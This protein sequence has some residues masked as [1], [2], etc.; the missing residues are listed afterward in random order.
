[1]KFF[2]YKGDFT[3]LHETLCNEIIYFN[4]C[5]INFKHNGKDIKWIRKLQAL[6]NYLNV[7]GNKCAESMNF[8]LNII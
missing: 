2:Y 3:L 8:D 6:I 4:C 7:Y 1:M 5:I